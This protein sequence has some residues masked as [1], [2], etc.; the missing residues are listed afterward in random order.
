[1][2]H[3]P[4]TGA[5]NDIEK[6]TSVARAMVTQ[7]GMTERIGAIKL[8]SENAE[9]FLGRDMGHQRDYSEEVAGVVDEEV[10]RLIE[11]RARRGLGDPGR[12]PRHPR[13]PGARAAREGDAGQGRRSPRSSPTSA[14][15]RPRPA[16]TG[17]DKRAPQAGP[18]M[19]PKELASPN[20]TNGQDKEHSMGVTGPDR[21]A[22]LARC[23]PTTIPGGRW[24]SRADRSGRAASSRTT[25]PGRR[26]R[27]ARTTTSGVRRAVR[28]LLVAIGED[29]DRDGLRDTPDRVAR[30]YRGDLRR[31]VA[32]ARGRADDDLRPRPRRDGA[33]QGHRGAQRRASTTWCRS[34]GS[35][36]SAT[37]RPT[38]AGS[39]GCPSWPG[40]STSTPAGRR[41]R[42]GMTTQIADSLMRILEP[43]GV[44]RRR[45]VRAP[46]HVD[47]R[48]PQAGRHDRDL[49]GARPA[50]R[51]RDPGRGD[52][53][54]RARGEPRPGCCPATVAARRPPGPA[55]AA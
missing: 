30:A 54:H 37:S 18:V 22:R 19:T 38:T 42:S 25:A 41:C 26:R 13:R 50:A 29:P 45:R 33:G 17:S 14:S 53:P 6:A 28:D 11:T 5:A 32:G 35:R 55:G 51:P 12:Q 9:P 48:H 2:F 27:S 49:G 3:D 10:K 8:G 44:D 43:R 23:R 1:M 36:T 20:G 16:W 15:G 31:A 24:G 34:P 40:W 7:Y 39:P 47:A 52:E 46:V 21:R 4:T